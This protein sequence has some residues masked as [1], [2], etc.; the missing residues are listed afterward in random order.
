LKRDLPA[1]RPDIGKEDQGC[2]RRDRR[3]RIETLKRVEELESENELHS[4]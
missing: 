3:V 4:P 2:T 1:G